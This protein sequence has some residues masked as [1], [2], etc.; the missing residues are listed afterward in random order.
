M[1]ADI[2]HTSHRNSPWTI[3]KPVQGQVRL[4]MLLSA[5]SAL[6]AMAVL[7]QL[8][9]LADSLR[10]ASQVWPWHPLL[11]AAAC[12]AASY[13]MRLNAFQQSHYAAFR[14]ETVLRTDLSTHLARIPLGQVQQLGAGTLAKVLQ[15]D[16]KELHIFV[17]D[18]TPLFARAYALPVLTLGV[19]LWLD[20]RLALAANAVVLGGF[21]VLS[22]AMRGHGDMTR[23]YNAARERVSAA[24]IEFVQAMPVVRS[25]DTG[26]T[27]FGRYQAALDAYLVV[28]TRWYR[29]A[30]FSAR[31][32][33]AVL[34]PMPTLAIL[35]WLGAWLTWQ[36]SLPFGVWLAVLLLGT[37]M[38][39]AMLPMMLLY[40]MVEKSRLS[41]ARINQVLQIPTMPMPAAQA[42]AA[43]H[44]ASVVFEHVDFSYAS[45]DEPALEDV[46]FCAPAGS[47]TALVGP[48]GAGKSTV[49]R[50][51]GRFWDVSGG[52]ILIGGVDVRQ[53]N[54]DT[55]MGHVG[56][57][58]QDTFLFADTIANN[59]RLGQPAASLEQV[60]AAARAAQAHDFIL[61][62]PNGYE[63]QAGEQGLFLSGG[64]R[65]RI[66]IARA[67][68]QNRPILVLDE[69]TA[70][71]DPENEAALV[72]ALSALMHGKTVLMVAHRLSTICDAQ[73]ILVFERGRLVQHGR[74]AE[75]L[76]SGGVYG[77]LWDN[78][79]QAQRWSLRAHAPH[80]PTLPQESLF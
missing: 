5:S 22:L 80:H 13:V 72:A 43:P 27:S 28:L 49:A 7:A 67:I 16:V 33:M 31:F 79:E 23:Q 38:A 41:I 34:N 54:A 77:H 30:G 48:S 20:W 53:M 17:A 68:L 1:P 52:R 2:K 29:N 75:L 66:T 21:G 59:I 26:R 78:H 15:D 61:A 9:W 73:Q 69:A 46:S 64:Q 60:H 50:L 6:L 56:M 47:M 44:D 32:S 11:G 71:A 10:R 37:G 36:A 51:I 63:T 70:F 57:V 45:D 25:F 39:E 76:A 14:L 24:V 3:I 40:H 62:L 55:L 12:T 4:A 58:F 42:S 74:H 35:L 8:A 18:S 65:Q 19:L